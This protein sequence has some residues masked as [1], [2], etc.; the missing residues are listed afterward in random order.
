[1]AMTAWAANASTNATCLASKGI[2]SR[3]A[4]AI[5]PMVAPLRIIGAIIIEL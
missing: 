4:V 5:A 2:A 1:M 3:C